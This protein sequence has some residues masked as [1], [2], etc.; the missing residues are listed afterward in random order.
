MIGGFGKIRRTHRLLM[1][2]L[3]VLIGLFGLTGCSISNKENIENNTGTSDTDSQTDAK[4]NVDVDKEEQAALDEKESTDVPNTEQENQKSYFGEWVINQVQAS[5]VGTY[6]EEDMES[7]IGK[8]ITFTKE[9]ASV[10]TD[11]LSDV[12]KVAENPIYTET[13]LSASDVVENYRIPL[14]SLGIEA[15]TVTEVVVT[16][17]NGYVSSFFIKDDDTLIL[18]GGGTYFELLRNDD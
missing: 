8:T 6:S 4:E 9:T 14:D 10:F 12:G 15:D 3:T 17:T 18:I 5:G 7:L 2:L 13:V 11:Q 1:V 16:D